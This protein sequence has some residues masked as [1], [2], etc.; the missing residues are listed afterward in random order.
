MEVMDEDANQ[1]LQDYVAVLKRRQK[2][3]MIAALLVLMLGLILAMV[4]P[5]TYR[6]TAVILIESQDVPPDLIRST[7]T[8][9]A[10]Q[11][12]EEIKQR[13]MTTG[14]I[15]SLV[16]RFELYSE[17]EL[18]RLTRTEISKEFRDNVSV[19]PISADVIDPR[20]GNPTKAVIAFKLAFDGDDP[21]KVH[22]VSNELITLYLN[23]NLRG[24]TEQ[25]NST[26]DFLSNEL[27]A[28]DK[29]LKKMEGQL[30]EFK[31]NNKD[32]L[33]ELNAYNLNTLD[34]AEREL[35]EIKTRMQDLESR[36]IELASQLAQLNPSSPTILAD[37]KAILSDADRLKA[38]QSDYRRK[39][40]IYRADHPDLVRL[41][42]EIRALI[43][44]QAGGEDQNYANQ[45][46]KMAREQLAQAQ[47]KYTSNHPEIKRLTKV[48][49]H[50]QQSPSV[51][52]DAFDVKPDN[53]SYVLLDTQ[54]KS[55]ESEMLSLRSK[56]IIV[57]KNIQETEQALQKAPAVEKEYQAL[58]RDYDSTRLKYREISEKQMQAELG[59]N[60]EQERKGERFTL[61]QPPELPE[62]PLSPNRLIM[63]LVSLVLAMG[64]GIATAVLLDSYDTKIYS[65]KKI[66]AITHIP[67]LVTIPFYQ[68]PV[69]Q[70]QQKRK[71]LGFAGLG[72]FLLLFFLTLFNFFIKP[73]DVTWFIVLHKLG[74][75]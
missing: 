14:N 72:I 17:R 36:K 60:L 49:A 34:R 45:Q 57:Q 50:L 16:Q 63:V 7:I 1:S 8:S 53:P 32:S 61:I 35:L 30:A 62:K 74:M 68:P 2:P 21:Q 28:L 47:G 31:E 9:Y 75:H 13:I 27:M 37:G 51:R 11:R 43:Q 6:S 59:K 25:S 15:M 29:I 5:A 46:L 26:S 39:A 70:Q 67:A 19:E 65:D 40:A 44:N 69:D 58:L 54:L 52:L 42:R 41:D 24:R 33:P 55:A 20:S 66:E 38:L 23:E 64:V 73:L 12:I 10:V 18:N 56:A 71:M 48:V 22:K 4:W 3:M